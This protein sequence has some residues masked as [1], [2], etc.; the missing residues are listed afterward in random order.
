M[1]FQGGPLLGLVS[2]FLPSARRLATHRPLDLPPSSS[3]ALP[4]P[5]GAHILKSSSPLLTY[6]IKLSHFTSKSGVS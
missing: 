2:P 3:Q 5:V 4:G 1:K 6:I